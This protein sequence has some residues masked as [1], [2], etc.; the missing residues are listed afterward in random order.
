MNRI[1]SFIKNW[2][3]AVLLMILGALT[4]YL[5]WMFLPQQYTAVVPLSIGIDYNRTGK[6]E[7]IEQDRLLG[8]AEDVLHSDKVMQV[9][10]AESGEEDYQSFFSRT[11]L[12]R[13]NETWSLSITGDEPEMTG[14]LAVLWLDTARQGLEEGL[15][16][17]VRA[18]AF[19]N[20]LDGL[21]RCIQNSVQG[22][23]PIACPKSSDETILSINTAAEQLRI[24]KE[25]SYGLS[26]ALMLG[27]KAPGQ[28]VIHPAA[29]SAAVDTFLGALCGLI[30]AFALVWFQSDG[31]ES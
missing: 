21:T 30:V 4:G 13:T 18:E 17:A 24:E 9:V 16:H 3:R 10:F 20:Q 15:D 26:S 6:L 31:K 29:R 5:L 23:S 14:K 25:Q 28:L 19:Q 11:H 1:E 27:S 8:L 7:D 22:N 12:T 2:P